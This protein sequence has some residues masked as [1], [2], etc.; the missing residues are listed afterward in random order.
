MRQSTSLNNN[1]TDWM[2]D[3]VHYHTALHSIL[4]FVYDLAPC[5][6]IFLKQRSKKLFL[7]LLKIDKRIK[8]TRGDSWNK[9][10]YCLFPLIV[11]H[12]LHTYTGNFHM[13]IWFTKLMIAS[14][15]VVSSILLTIFISYFTEV[16]KRIFKSKTVQQS[17]IT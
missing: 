17:L 16:V 4:N 1:I 13:C 6:Q 7:W 11:I 14:F 15:D 3:V 5:L 2:K 8:P 9:S 12:F 10:K